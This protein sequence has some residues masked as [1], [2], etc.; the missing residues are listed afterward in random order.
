MLVV[1]SLMTLALPPLAD[2]AKDDPVA[3][4]HASQALTHLR[5]I[6]ESA[7][8]PL[9]SIFL[10]TVERKKLLAERGGDLLVALYRNAETQALDTWLGLD[11]GKATADV[12][13]L[14]AQDLKLRG[15]EDA[16]GDAR[17]GLK[18]RVFTRSSH[19]LFLF[20][21]DGRCGLASR[22]SLSLE[23]LEVSTKPLAE[24]SDFKAV[25]SLDSDA[26]VRG[27][28]NIQKYY[29][30]LARTEQG[31]YLSGLVRR[32]GLDN[33]VAASLAVR[34]DGKKRLETRVS[35]VAPKPWQGVLDALGPAVTSETLVAVPQEFLGFMRVSIRPA[36]LWVVVQK[37]LAQASAMEFTLAQAQLDA[38]Q[39]EAKIRI[40]DALGDEPKAWALVIM[41]GAGTFD[42]VLVAPVADAEGLGKI[43]ERY[44]RIL[45][46]IAPD[47]K[48]SVAESPAGRIL[49][50]GWARKKGDP[51]LTL[52]VQAGKESRVVVASSAAALDAF[53]QQ[54]GKIRL[55]PAEPA[56]LS[57][58]LQDQALGLWLFDLG[59]KPTG[60]RAAALGKV[61]HRTAIKRKDLEAVLSTTTF[62]LKPTDE[63]LLLSVS[64]LAK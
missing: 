10:P 39:D 26:A 57:G 50:L 15:Y 37:V 43:L 48:L 34:L 11:A 61:L 27:R 18:T 25:A 35:V 33:L 23:A 36:R 8:G 24:S 49:S 46:S 16:A 19:G 12:V 62:A 4:L 9:L 28:V 21:A 53:L 5:E 42:L 47:L 20:Q 29:G 3:Y 1:V 52:A 30:Y 54:H 17:P 58:A 45:P 63:G 7:F 2:V 14:W 59:A 38:L 56:I 55:A 13:A 32:L 22:Q 31:S 64:T 60:S 51:F 6:D 41:P 40:D 44:G